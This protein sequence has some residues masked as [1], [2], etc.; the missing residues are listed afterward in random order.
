M[1]LSIKSPVV[2][3]LFTKLW[4]VCLLGT[5]HYEIYVTVF[6]DTF[7]QIHISHRC[8]TE[9][10]VALNYTTLLANCNWKQTANAADNCCLLPTNHKQTPTHEPHSSPWNIMLS[11][12]PQV[13]YFPWSQTLSAIRHTDYLARFIWSPQKSSALIAVKRR[14]MSQWTKLKNSVCVRDFRFQLHRITVILYNIYIE[15]GQWY[16]DIH[17]YGLSYAVA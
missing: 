4:I 12:S 15:G 8:Y 9:I 2:L 13:K 6:A 10:D 3:R 14:T 17:I 1:F 16:E 5:L 11:S 7:H